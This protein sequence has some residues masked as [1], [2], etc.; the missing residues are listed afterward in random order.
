MAGGLDSGWGGPASCRR[1]GLAG[2]VVDTLGGE[3]CQRRWQPQP[4]PADQS[5]LVTFPD[6]ESGAG[7]CQAVQIRQCSSRRPKATWRVISI[8]PAA[9]SP[10]LRAPPHPPIQQPLHP[11]QAPISASVASPP[12]GAASCVQPR[13]RPCGSADLSVCTRG[14]ETAR[15]SQPVAAHRHL[16]QPAPPHPAG[17]APRRPPRVRL[18][19]PHSK[20]A[21][22]APPRPGLT[23]GSP[24]WPAA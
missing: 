11:A 12:H 15:C 10:T 5:P 20:A 24:P 3:A 13:H 2:G 7:T 9:G 6:H 14:Q 21:A 22:L 17:S 16:L 4:A 18:E 23:P 8:R 1:A 19:A